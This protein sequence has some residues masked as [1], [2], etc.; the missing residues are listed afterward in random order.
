MPRMFDHK[1]FFSLGSNI[2]NRLMSLSAALDRLCSCG[3]AI[4]AK[5][6]IWETAPWG[7]TDQPRFLNICAEARTDLAPDAL[8]ALVKDIELALGRTVSRRWGPRKIDIDI[9]FYDSLIYESTALTIPHPR[10]HERGFV[11][12]PLSEIAPSY[13]HPR[14]GLS[15]AELV[16]KIPQ[17]EKDEMVWVS[18]I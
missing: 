11:L 5:S 7:V 13:V 14:L 12:L 15:V 17:G 2:G 1:V 9:I 8:L 10:M 3:V 16:E 6:R 18:E 4:T